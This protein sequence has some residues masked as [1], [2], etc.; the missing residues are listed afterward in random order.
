MVAKSCSTDIVTLSTKKVNDAADAARAHA[1]S[2]TTGG[3]YTEATTEGHSSANRGQHERL[4][5]DD[6]PERN[7]SRIAPPG[8]RRFLHPDRRG[9]NHG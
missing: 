2:T 6:S 1:D 8:K 9:V 5:D 7:V 3:G 4:D